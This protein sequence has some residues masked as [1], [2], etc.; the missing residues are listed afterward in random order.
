MNSVYT[1][2]FDNN[3]YEPIW[4]LYRYDNGIVTPVV[5]SE[6]NRTSITA[7]INMSGVTTFYILGYRDRYYYSLERAKNEALRLYK[8]SI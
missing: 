3:D 7:S 8:E 5:D 4:H 2:S 1:W 6:L